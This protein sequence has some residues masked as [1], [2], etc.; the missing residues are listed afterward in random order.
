MNIKKIEKLALEIRNEFENN[1]IDK[2]LL[3][4]LYQKYNNLNNIDLFVEK[5]KDLFPHLNCGLVTLYL[6]YRLSSGEIVQGRYNSQKHTFL[7][8]HKEYVVDI[9]DDQ[10]GGPEVYVGPLTKPRSK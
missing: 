7:L 3:K 8:L 6:K 1:K 9:T 10:Y 5:S 4:N 2:R